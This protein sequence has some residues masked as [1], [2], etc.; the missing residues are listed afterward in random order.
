LIDRIGQKTFI[1]TVLSRRKDLLAQD[2]DNTQRETFMASRL[3]HAA[4]DYEKVLFVGGLAHIPGILERLHEPQ[5]L[6]LMK[7][8]VSAALLAPIHPDSLKRGFTEIPKITEAF[9]GWRKD[10]D[11]PPQNRHD[12][13]VSLMGAAIDYYTR[14][15]R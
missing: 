4:R 1:E 5:P 2:E 8:G 9:E 11:A 6:P 14:Q 12:I 7:T 15:T 13:I 10:T 3:Q